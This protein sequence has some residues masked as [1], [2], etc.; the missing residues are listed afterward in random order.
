MAY[1]GRVESWALDHQESTCF[2]FLLPLE[3]VVE[4]GELIDI[5]DCMEGVTIPENGYV[6]VDV[7]ENPI[8][9]VIGNVNDR[10]SAE[11]EEAAQKPQ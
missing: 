9:V 1:S 10:Y 4:D 2:Y 6:S 7:S 5:R 11:Q 3:F 8:Y